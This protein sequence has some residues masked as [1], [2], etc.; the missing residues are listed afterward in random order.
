M[1][2]NKLENIEMGTRLFINL[3]FTINMFLMFLNYTPFTSL[4]INVLIPVSF[5]LY[6]LIVVTIIFS[7]KFFIN[8]EML[9]FILVFGMF[10]TY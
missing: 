4:K 1:K 8:K 9:K 10:S 7:K 3:F 5:T 2:N 6:I